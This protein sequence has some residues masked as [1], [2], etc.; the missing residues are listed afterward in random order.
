M[1]HLAGLDDRV[2]ATAKPFAAALQK[3]GKTVEVFEYPGVNHAFNNDT[4]ADRYNKAA[5]D[6][7]WDRTLR[8][9]KRYLG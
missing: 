4:A 2:A 3:A 9:F 6:L 8:F 5:A 7:A 1:L